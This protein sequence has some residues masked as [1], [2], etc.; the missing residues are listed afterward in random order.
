MAN[1]GGQSIGGIPNVQNNDLLFS[2]QGGSLQ[3][4]NVGARQNLNSLKKSQIS[5]QP[6]NNFAMM[7]MNMA[8]GMSTFAGGK[9]AEDE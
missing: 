5:G 4:L 9:H 6:P 7:Q 2:S 1:Q 3:M 8:P